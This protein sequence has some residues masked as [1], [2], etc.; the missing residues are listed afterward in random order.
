MVPFVDFVGK[1]NIKNN[2]F[3]KNVKTASN[4]ALLLCA[5]AVLGGFIGS[6]H[7]LHFSIIPRVPLSCFTDASLLAM[8]FARAQIYGYVCRLHQ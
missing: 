3:F 1:T 2:D 8:A 4:V 5:G 6:Y 7:S